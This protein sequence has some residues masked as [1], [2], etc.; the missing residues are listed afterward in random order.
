[1][2]EIIQTISNSYNEYLPLVNDAAQQDTGPCLKGMNL[3]TARILIVAQLGFIFVHTLTYAIS[4]RLWNAF[5]VFYLVI[6]IAEELPNFFNFV[7]TFAV[8]FG[9]EIGIEN[10]NG[11]IQRGLY[12]WKPVMQ[13]IGTVALI[14]QLIPMFMGT[15]IWTF[16]DGRMDEKL[17]QQAMVETVGV[18]VPYIGSLVLFN[19]SMDYI[20]K[21]QHMLF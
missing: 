21:E 11:Q 2:D 9:E 19:I 13:F 7:I 14:I 5:N 1:M 18:L 4:L 10:Q 20:R 3:N 17:G 15:Y 12:W 8:V 6:Y 16:S